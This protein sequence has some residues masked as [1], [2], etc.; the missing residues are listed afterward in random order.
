LNYFVHT[1]GQLLIREIILGYNHRHPNLL[2]F[3]GVFLP[4]D[5]LEKVYL[6]SPFY[7]NGTIVEYLKKYPTVER[8]L[9][10][11]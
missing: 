10:V 4:D 3:E 6:V 1:L 5:D 9:L 11:R 2:P 7:A 8:R